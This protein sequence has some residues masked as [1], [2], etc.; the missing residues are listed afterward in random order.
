MLAELKQKSQ[1]TIPKE[2]TEKL[3]LKIGDTLQIDLVNDKIVITPVAVIPK[4]QAWFYT[5]VWQNM[6]N[7]NLYSTNFSEKLCRQLEKEMIEAGYTKPYAKKH[8]KAYKSFLDAEK[9][10][11]L[12]NI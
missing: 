9:N 12:T 1:L 10:D 2:F 5:K 4:N 6:T 7:E 11:Q 8:A 3:E